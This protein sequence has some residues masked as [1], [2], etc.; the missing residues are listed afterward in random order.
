MMAS[1]A[2]P[3]VIQLV[4]GGVDVAAR[5]LAYVAL[6]AAG[7]GFAAGLATVWTFTGPAPLGRPRS[8]LVIVAGA[9][10][11]AM[12]L[13]ALA[14]SLVVHA[15][16]GS[17]SG[18]HAHSHCIVTSLAL[19]AAPLG[20]SFYVFRCSDPVLPWAT[21]AALGAVAAS[22]GG[23]T[24]ALQCPEMGTSHVALAHA[25]PIAL[26]ALLGAVLGWRVLALRWIDVA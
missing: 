16:L 3:A 8:R 22:W 18:W 1:S 24:L 7:S 4:R 5:P 25:G 20:A 21:G 15:P 12:F 2:L 11:V 6:V 14:A 9:L 23:V 10:P 26:G 13:V 19:L 17:T